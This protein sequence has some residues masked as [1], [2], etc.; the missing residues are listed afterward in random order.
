[1]TANPT[2]TFALCE[3]CSQLLIGNPNWPDIT[4]KS[5][6]FIHDPGRETACAGGDWTMIEISVA[7]ALAVTINGT[8]VEAILKFVQA[9][10]EEI[11]AYIT[12]RRS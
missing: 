4:G 1:M 5:K 3:G 12:G 8:S 2:I 7:D 6:R 11:R 10:D 9:R